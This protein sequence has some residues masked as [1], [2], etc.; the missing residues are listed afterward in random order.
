M[1]N[2]IFKIVSF[3][4]LLLFASSCIK[5][6]YDVENCPSWITVTPL[7]PVELDS[8]HQTVLENTNSSMICPDYGEWNRVNI[9]PEEIL[10]L[11]RGYYQFFA[12]KDENEHITQERS[13][14]SISIKPDG[15]AQEPN[16]F[17]GG[18]V[19]FSLGNSLE[20]NIAINHNLQTYIQSRQL[21]LRVKFVGDN[22]SEIKKVDAKVEG[23]AT[24]RELLYGF[25]EGG[26]PDR[27]PALYNGFVNYHFDGIDSDGYRS[28]G[29]RLLGLDAEVP[30]ILTLTVTYDDDTVRKF[31]FDIT[32]G[33]ALSS[34]LSN[35]L[36][37]FMTN[38]V[39]LPFVIKMTVR[40][41]IDFSAQIID[42]IAGPEL[43]LDAKP[44]N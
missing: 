14:L 25:K 42:W 3:S 31:I 15:S 38:E 29:R 44:N 40:V 24:K 27:Y 36:N 11:R 23:I 33:S 18:S 28:E 4:L 41:G 7:V 13:T 12:I 2:R 5:S 26:T 35:G 22:I 6:K 43:W 10:I 30:Q 17:V 20:D 8:G 21:V 37:G 32:D 16:L 1:K 39:T 34:V 9:G 19:D